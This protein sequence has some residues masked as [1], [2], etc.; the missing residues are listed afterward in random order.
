M[1]DIILVSTGNE[2]IWRCNGKYAVKGTKGCES[3]HIDDKVL[4]QAFVGAF[5][6]MVEKKDYFMEKWQERLERDNILVRYKAKQF[7]AI[8]AAG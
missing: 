6:A 3:R 2:Y 4:Y 1:E 7:M 5:N 8:L